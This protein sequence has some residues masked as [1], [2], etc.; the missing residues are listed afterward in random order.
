VTYRLTR[1]TREVDEKRSSSA[2]PRPAPGAVED[3][4]ARNR[5]RFVLAAVLLLQLVLLGYQVK[6]GENVR[7]W[8]FWVVSIVTPVEQSLSAAAGFLGSHW[9]RYVWLVEAREENDRLKRELNRLKL[10]NL[11]LR[12]A[13]DR[14]ER[15]RRLASYQE[16]LASETLAAR[17][18]G[19][20]A[21]WRSRE[22]FID[23]GSRHGVR[24]GMGVTTPEGIVGKVQAAYPKSSLVQ[25]IDDVDGGVGV[26]LARS[27]VHGVL[28]GAGGGECLLDYVPREARIEAGELVYTSGN[29]RV[30]PRGL[31]VG[32]VTRLEEGAE[33]KGVYVHPFAPLNRLDEVLVVT[34]GVHR[35]LPEDP[36]PQA[37]RYLSPLPPGENTEVA[38][39]ERS[40]GFATEAD[41][42]RRHYEAVGDA[43]GHQFGHG[44]PGSR[45]P[46]FNLDPEQAE[47][48]DSRGA[49]AS[50]TRQRAA[51][52]ASGAPASGD[53][54]FF[55]APARAA[56]P[57]SAADR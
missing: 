15:E 14:L 29:D 4:F 51:P 5:N 22:V 36:K 39:G 49:G 18:I 54:V 37:P 50:G 41:R 48:A 45:A 9:K 10:A 13:L 23:R 40:S 44:K 24:S 16:E 53:A 2:A 20:G 6:R 35:D 56:T 30:F 3:F 34:R 52:E 11:N 33:F 1:V 19:V 12:R 43:Q 42:L 31:P 17:V 38:A 26:V 8:R 55:P 25:L 57:P 7:L 21:G 27:R 47:S 46:D 28:K 32:K